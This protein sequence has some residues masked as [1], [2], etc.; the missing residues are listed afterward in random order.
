[1]LVRLLSAAMLVAGAC[2]LF[3]QQPSPGAVQVQGADLPLIG[4]V[5]EVATKTEAVRGVKIPRLP[6]AVR[7]PA[8]ERQGAVSARAAAM[9][10]ADRLAA[11]GRAW[12][13][14]GLGNAATPA[15]VIRLLAEDLDGVCLDASGSKL[16]V[17]PTR[18]PESD[19]I[20]VRENGK[21]ESDDS[22]MTL[23]V[24]TGVRPD[25][26]LVAHFLI[27]VLQ[28]ARRSAPTPGTTDALLADA[29]WREGEANLAALLYLFRGMGLHDEVLEGH[30]EPSGVLD[31]RLVPAA[32]WGA[33]AVERSFLEFV[34]LEGVAQARERVAKGTWRG[35]NDA[36]GVRRT[37]RDV[38]HPDR[39][40]VTVMRGG[41]DN[42]L[43]GYAVADEDVLG[44]QGIVTL[45]STTTGKDNLA[46][47]SAN[48]WEGDRLRRIEP[49]AGLAELGYT[50]WESFWA[51]EARAK[52][53]EYGIERTLEARFPGK[54]PADAGAG[55]RL[56]ATEDSV[57]RLE[58]SGT[59]VLVRVAPPAVDAKLEAARAP[60][61]SPKPG[62]SNLKK[63]K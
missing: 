58:R 30:V 13:G 27:H 4:D 22:A 11:R 33:P 7:A 53:F 6:L 52:D 60:H 38:L 54:T 9:V 61:G 47:L 19:L 48:G 18:L 35:L 10:P 43:A 40:P 56:L 14:L 45:V 26:P 2:A 46:L 5:R 23:V 25:E 37:T 50:V 12:E 21:G 59:R 63:N 8:S 3:A 42:F 57:Y 41:Q 17:D 16:L 1:M 31:G 62:P 44:E 20:A 49:S 39:A 55:R 36:A 15:A 29:A 51:D 34:Y 32:L 24:A 28:D